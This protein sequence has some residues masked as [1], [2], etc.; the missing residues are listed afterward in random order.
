MTDITQP[1][2]AATPADTT[3]EPTPRP[4]PSEIARWHA[5]NRENFPKQEVLERFARSLTNLSTHPTRH[6]SMARWLATFGGSGLTGLALGLYLAKSQWA[7]HTLPNSLAFGLAFGLFVLTIAGFFSAAGYLLSIGIGG[8]F[9]QSTLPVQQHSEEGA[10]CIQLKID[11]HKAWSIIAWERETYPL[12]TM[13]G[14][15]LF[16]RINEDELRQAI[17]AWCTEHKATPKQLDLS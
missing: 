5:L 6:L 16:A 12:A 1:R 3:A 17:T 7:D 15:E 13:A 8:V 14:Q 2:D 10:Y 11:Q 9:L 4:L